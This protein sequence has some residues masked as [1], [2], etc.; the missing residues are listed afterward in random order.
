MEK[1]LAHRTRN[2]EVTGTT[3]RLLHYLV[4]IWASCSQASASVAKQYNLV[5]RKQREDKQ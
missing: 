4:K 3:L 1:W 2:Q 5:L